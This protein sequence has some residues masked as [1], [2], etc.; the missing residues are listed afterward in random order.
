MNRYTIEV[1]VIPRAKKISVRQD[2]GLLK[3]YLTAP[4]L[5][6]KANSQ[7]IDVLSEYL[8]VPKRCIKIVKGHKSR[9]KVVEVLIR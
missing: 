4:P 1:K 2:N 8:D 9:N 6:D 3:V 7:L 5:D